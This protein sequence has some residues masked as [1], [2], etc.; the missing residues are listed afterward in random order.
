ML[1]KVKSLATGPNFGV[2]TTMLPN[3]TAMSHMMWVDADDDCILINTEIHRRKFTNMAIG[4]KATVL[5]FENPFS[6]VEVRGE[7]VEHVGGEAA[8]AHIDACSQRY[9]GTDYAMP[10]QSE[11]V[12]VRIRP[13]KEFEF[14]PK[15]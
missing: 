14:P 1:D 10:V 9:S 6:W 2:L 5:V 4:A 3:G 12:I 8:R 11:R 15:M 7:V 13:S